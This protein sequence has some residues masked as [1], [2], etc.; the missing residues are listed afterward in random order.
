MYFLKPIS[1]SLFVLFFTVSAFAQESE[2]SVATIMQDPASYIG[3]W[4]S[5]PYW[6]EDGQ[7]LYFNWNPMGK[8]E[9]DSLFKI[10]REDL[11]PQQVSRDE[12]LNQGPVFDGW[13]HGEHV[14]DSDF[15]HKVYVRRGDLYL[16][17]RETGT[18]TRLTQTRGLEGSPRFALA[19]DAI[20]FERDDN[21]YKLALDSGKLAQLTDLRDGRAPSESKPD[22]QGAFLE[23][24]QS[25]LFE[26]IREEQ[27]ED[28]LRTAARERDE[29]ALNPPPTWYAGSKSISQLQ[30]DPTERYVSFVTSPPPESGKRTRAMDWVTESGYTEVLNARVKVGR[31]PQ[32]RNL[33]IQDLTRDTTYQIDLHQLEG[34]Y[35]VPKYMRE[36]G[37]EVDSSKSKRALFSFGPFWSAD[38]KHAVLEVRTDDN[39]DRWLARLD[40]ATGTLDL[41]DRQHDEAWIA[42]PGICWFGG[43]STGGWLPD[44][45]H[46]Y[47]QSEASGH[48]H[49]YTVNVE[50][51]EVNQLTE[52][53]FEVFD[54]EL[55]QDGRTW[56]FTSSEGSPSIRHFYRMPV[57]GGK[58]ERLT[59]LPGRNAAVR[60]PDGDIL[61]I[62]NSIQTRPP[63]VF[64][65]VPTEEA[66][67]ITHSQTETWLA[68]SWRAPETIHFEA[69][70]GVMVPAHVF[71]PVEPNGAAVLFVHGAGYMQNVHDGWSSYYREYMF[72]NLL[73]DL[74]YVVIQVDFRAS[75]GYGR[76]WRTAI[77]RHMGGR[78]L[79]DYVDASQY[80][81]KTYGIGPD[82]IG[83]YGGSYGGFITLMALF[84][85]PEYFGAGAALRSVTDWAHYNHT[86]TSNILN[87]PATDSL[88]FARS[89]PI[90]FAE[91]LEDPLLMPHGMIDLNVQFQDIVRLGQR[92][93]ELGKEDWEIALYPVEG[94]GFQEPSSWTDEYRRILK[95]FE[96]HIRP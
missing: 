15:S 54:P 10:T 51:G 81:T 4:P 86:Y 3:N 61:G 57:T 22:E 27:E 9:S 7:T 28:E 30:L 59:T 12:R 49:L 95:L 32:E 29:N 74:G 23:A 70:D 53:P 5:T 62:L 39:K 38:G 47:F 42:G 43:G 36:E 11:T 60:A 56:F 8:F 14:Y 26:I 25:E 55:S 76:D 19:G 88:A 73:A 71:E 21:L 83:I 34:A 80:I 84:T 92:L 24:Q 65:Q 90:N 6:S 68:Y 52:G 13:Q 63:E 1:A 91:G 35:D 37:V 50:T 89:S 77:Y 82:H 58:R 94:H 16:F 31:V 48:S 33:H 64:V 18:Q 96:E 66:A 69:S 45:R 2:L 93:I 67:R 46:Y 44:N 87:T 17:E 79:Q 20:I 78:D 40:P 41:L 85:E 72:H 75:A